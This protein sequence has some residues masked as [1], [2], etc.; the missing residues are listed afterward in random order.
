MKD[1]LLE[2]KVS[3][4]K[5]SQGKMEQ[6]LEKWRRQKETQAEDCSFGKTSHPANPG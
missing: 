1:N 2:E 6:K 3:E 5:Q 4:E